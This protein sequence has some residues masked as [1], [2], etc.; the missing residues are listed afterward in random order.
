MSNTN[1][2]DTLPVLA[3]NDP[4]VPGLLAIDAAWAAACAVEARITGKP[5][6]P[7]DLVANVPAASPTPLRAT[8]RDILNAIGL[9][10]LANRAKAS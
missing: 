9:P 2:P 5:F 8:D 10:E 4:R 3:H 1:A 6:P 7:T